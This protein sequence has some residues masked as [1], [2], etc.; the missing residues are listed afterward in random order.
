M[1]SGAALRARAIS[2]GRSIRYCC[3]GAMAGYGDLPSWA[4]ETKGGIAQKLLQ[5]FF[6]P[7]RSRVWDIDPESWMRKLKTILQD[8]LYSRTPREAFP[9]SNRLR[10]DRR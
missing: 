4:W 10:Q 1:D 5:C 8:E 6:L 2:A 9:E 3:K 7:A